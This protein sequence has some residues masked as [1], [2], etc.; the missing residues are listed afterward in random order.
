[1]KRILKKHWPL[2]G[3]GA[4]L[5]VVILYLTQ[6][7]KK[8]V[9][10]SILTNLVPEEGLKLKNIHYT[11]NDPDKGI[12]WTLDAKEVKF[13]KDRTFFSFRDFRL[14]VEPQE[15]PRIELEGKRG[16][17]D[18]KSGEINLH[19]DLLGYTDNGYR[20]ITEHLLYSEKKRYLKTEVPVKIIGPFFTVD[21]RGL[22]F[23][24]DK[25]TLR[26][27][28]DVTTHINKGSLNL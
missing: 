8:T 26:I 1:M 12:K 27:M 19:G 20:I 24:P 9:A 4:L 7:H 22:H 17:Y 2:I 3:I 11:Q 14:K 28:S 16:D 5:I 6:A 18:K 23:N 15:R 25:E 21:G 10:E 13:S